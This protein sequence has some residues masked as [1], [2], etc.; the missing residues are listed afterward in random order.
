MKINKIL[1]CSLTNALLL[2]NSKAGFNK[3]DIQSAASLPA[4]QAIHTGENYNNP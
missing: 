4:N 3:Q 2:T 1:C